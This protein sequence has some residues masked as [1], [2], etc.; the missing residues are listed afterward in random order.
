MA[1]NCFPAMLYQLTFPPGAEENTY[2]LEPA[3]INLVR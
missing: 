2:F 3:L 1:Q